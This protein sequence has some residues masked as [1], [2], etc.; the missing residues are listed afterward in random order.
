MKIVNYD[1]KVKEYLEIEVDD[2]D[3]R[4]YRRDLSPG[5]S[6]LSWEYCE[7]H[8]YDIWYPVM[9]MNKIDEL[10]DLYDSIINDNVNVNPDIDPDHWGHI[11]YDG[12]I[13]PY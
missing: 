1:K 13:D 5:T 8:V 12:I 10:N 6:V 3:Y 2:D 4:Y 9:H 7:D 11:D